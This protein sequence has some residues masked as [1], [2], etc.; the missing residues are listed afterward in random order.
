MRPFCSKL[1]P[2]P[3]ENS[4]PQSLFPRD[5]H[6]QKCPLLLKIGAGSLGPF[7][8][9]AW[10][11]N[12]WTEIDDSPQLEGYMV[13]PQS[14]MS[15]SFVLAKIAGL[16]LKALKGITFSLSVGWFCSQ[17]SAIAWF[18]DKLRLSLHLPCCPTHR[19]LSQQL[20]EL[21]FTTL[22]PHRTAF[23]ATVFFQLALLGSKTQEESQFIAQKPLLRG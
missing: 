3:G 17:S 7:P 16:V 1:L 5:S 10:C 20:P 23:G 6:F 2:I 4:L 21:L 14:Y 12:R 13:K 11:N 19:G 8:S 9:S 15:H 22:P 18:L